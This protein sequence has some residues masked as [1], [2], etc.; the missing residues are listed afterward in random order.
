MNHATLTLNV[1]A[2]VPLHPTSSMTTL[3]IEMVDT[4]S[5]P[6]QK[7]VIAREK[8]VF[9]KAAA[10]ITGAILLLLPI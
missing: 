5:L 6:I 2:S 1:A 7:G 4:L 3:E 8:L 9:V 10:F